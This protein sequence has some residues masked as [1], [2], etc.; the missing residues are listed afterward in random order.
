MPVSVRLALLRYIVI[1]NMTIYFSY[2]T[3]KLFVLIKF[4][5]FYITVVNNAGLIVALNCCFFCL[6]IKLMCFVQE[7]GLQLGL[8]RRYVQFTYRDLWSSVPKLRFYFFL[9]VE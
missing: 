7:M 6:P 4:F 1:K 5:P 3:N 2:Q 9:S 8:Q